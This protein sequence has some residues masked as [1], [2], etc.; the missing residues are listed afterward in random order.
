[1]EFNVFTFLSVYVIISMIMLL[2]TIIVN[3]KEL[4]SYPIL[5]LFAN[6]ILFVIISP[7][8]TIWILWRIYIG[9]LK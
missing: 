5:S 4:D 7:I 3:G 9:R 8:M 1:M 2:N 6:M